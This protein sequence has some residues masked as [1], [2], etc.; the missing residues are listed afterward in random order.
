MLLL[1]LFVVT[2]LLRTI[3]P[4]L[5]GRSGH[6]G[7][8]QLLRF[9]TSTAGPTA[10]SSSGNGSTTKRKAEDERLCTALTELDLDAVSAALRDG[11]D[12]DCAPPFIH[13]PVITST[14]DL[15]LLS[16]LEQAFDVIDVLEAAQRAKSGAPAPAA[17]EQQQE[18][19]PVLALGLL[20]KNKRLFKQLFYADEYLPATEMEQWQR[21]MDEQRR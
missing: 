3:A 18:S 20:K 15:V 17:T 2:M 1:L 19:R 12:P 9:S 7:L 4:I 8:D 5:V 21:D 13:P 14:K 11:A 10:P 16:A 6:R